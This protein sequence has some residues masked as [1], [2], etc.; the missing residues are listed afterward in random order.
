MF[1][2]Q[3]FIL[4]F[5]FPHTA[6]QRF[7]ERKQLFV[8]VRFNICGA[9]DPKDGFIV[10]VMI[11]H[12]V[13]DYNRVLNIIKHS[14]STGSYENIYLANVSQYKQQQKSPDQ[15]NMFNNYVFQTKVQILSY[16]LCLLV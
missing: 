7:T 4:L 8:P 11:Q 12:W 1:P 10:P 14:G 15:N 5:L 6:F 3:C 2:D 13:N 9:N 16:L